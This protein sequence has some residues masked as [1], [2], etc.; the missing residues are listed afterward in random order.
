MVVLLDPKLVP[1]QVS[2]LSSSGPGLSG[3]CPSSDVSVESDSS[4][5]RPSL[6]KSISLVELDV[7]DLSSSGPF[8]V[9]EHP[10]DE[11]SIFGIVVLSDEFGSGEFDVTPSSGNG[12]LSGGS[13]PVLEVPSLSVV[14]DVSLDGDDIPSSG[15][16]DSSLDN[17][18][19]LVVFDIRVSSLEDDVHSSS[20]DSLSSVDEFDDSVLSSNSSSGPSDSVSGPFASLSV[21]ELLK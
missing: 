11:S 20:S 7:S 13:S 17:S 10:F 15:P 19:L 21:L 16:S 12:E 4:S 5:G 3:N 18:V 8:L 14:S 2:S 9:S 1:S 6:S